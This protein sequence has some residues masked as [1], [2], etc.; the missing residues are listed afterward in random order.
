MILLFQ[1][2]LIENEITNVGVYLLTQEERDKLAGVVHNNS[3]SQ[4]SSSNHSDSDSKDSTTVIAGK[5]K[6]ALNNFVC[7][8]T[9]NYVSYLFVVSRKE[10][11]I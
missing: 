1:L 10:I 4:M 11:Y 5:K 8:N 9:L 7:K 2:S 3:N 6:K